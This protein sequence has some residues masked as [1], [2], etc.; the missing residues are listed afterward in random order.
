MFRA[1]DGDENDVGVSN[2]TASASLSL[3][4][5]MMMLMALAEAHK[6]IILYLIIFILHKKTHFTIDCGC[7]FWIAQHLLQFM[8]KSDSE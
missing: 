7:C 6:D 4:L 1:N 8:R 5:L 3:M 2:A